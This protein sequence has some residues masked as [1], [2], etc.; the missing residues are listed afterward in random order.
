PEKPFT[1]YI[2]DQNGIAR[3]RIRFSAGDVMTTSI[4]SYTGPGKGDSGAWTKDYAKNNNPAE[5]V[6][7]TTDWK[8][9]NLKKLPLKI[10]LK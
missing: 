4:Y 6:E 7:E 5:N 10:E 8:K 1:V 9:E 3:Y 2:F